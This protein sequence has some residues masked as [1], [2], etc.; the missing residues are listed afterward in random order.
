M[1]RNALIAGTIGL[2]LASCGGSA[3]PPERTADKDAPAAPADH[4]ESLRVTAEQQKA[5][6]FEYYQLQ[7]GT[8]ARAIRTTGVIQANETRLAQIRALSTG[9]ILRVLV[10]VGDQVKA[11]QPL[12]VYDNIE[13]GEVVHEYYGAAAMLEG[14]RSTALTAELALE[15]ARSLVAVGAIAQAEV[16]RREREVRVA[17]NNVRAQT[18]GLS[19]YHEKLARFG[20]DEAQ[21]TDLLNRKPGEYH[22]DE[23][24]TTLRAP[25]AGVVLKAA[26]VQG[27]TVQVDNQ[28][29]EIADTSTVW[30]QADLYPRDLGAV[31]L[32]SLARVTPE[33]QP[34]EPVEGRITLIADAVNPETR[35]TRVRIEVPNP[36]RRLKLDMYATV[37]LP[38][39]SGAARLEIP[40]EAVQTVD[41][42]AVVF[43]RRAPEEFEIRRVAVG[44]E[45]RGAMEV[46]DGLRVG[47]TIVVRGSF[48]L[49]SE[50][51]KAALMDA[52][53]H[54]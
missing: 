38:A 17:Q 25:F 41:G 27:E 1:Y 47:E 6:R 21:I 31:R 37:E 43:V 4:Q 50:H 15:R 2:L 22:H 19:H 14:A 51:E 18:A 52:E 3:K 9:R 30:V 24:E 54:D 44:P 26:A 36:H 29:L 11:G 46:R 16:E 33:S 39:A 13:L 28:L 7:P 49:K 12:L 10:R 48:T 5:A 45:E 8:G 20:L 53:H 32:G 42:A 34:G 40:A 23:S 35:T